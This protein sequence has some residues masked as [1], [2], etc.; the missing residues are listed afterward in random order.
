MAVMSDIE[1][2]V[3][4]VEED[5][6][7]RVRVVAAHVHEYDYALDAGMVPIVENGEDVPKN[8]V[9]AA[10]KAQAEDLLAR[11]AKSKSNTISKRALAKVA[12]I[13]VTAEAPGRRGTARG[14]DR[15]ALRGGRRQRVPCV[16]G[17]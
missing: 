15:R 2:T 3:E 8:R 11:K 12:G 5:E 4:V 14:P 1:G 9:L 16:A 6:Q 10:P 17:R 7:R 13:G